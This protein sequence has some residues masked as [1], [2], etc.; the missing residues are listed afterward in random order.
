MEPVT[1][2]FLASRQAFE[3]AFHQWYSPL[4][5]F[6][7][8]YLQDHDQSE[9]TVQEYFYYLWNNREKINI[10]GS[11]ASYF[12]SSVKNRCLNQLKHFT[13]R[14]TYKQENQNVRDRQEGELVS[15]PEFR[16]MEE[17]VF[18]AV[19]ELPPAR[20]E[21]FKLS[22]FEG[23]SYKEIAQR[24]EITE[25]TVENQM[26]RALKTLREKLGEFLVL[27]VALAVYIL[28]LLNLNGGQ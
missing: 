20:K 14:D 11:L 19:E 6:A 12:F 9:D 26:G 16:D 15:E 22:R 17:K 1:I 8:K 21:V 3:N 25:K 10:T 27:A 18:V 4:C 28:K 23:L 13:I 2:D 7:Y 5:A 24:M